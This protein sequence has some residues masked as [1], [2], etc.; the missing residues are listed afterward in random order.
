MNFTLFPPNHFKVWSNSEFQR[1]LL[2]FE[3]AYEKD[4]FSKYIEY[5]RIL[6]SFWPN[7]RG[8]IPMQ[9]WFKY[10]RTWAWMGLNLCGCHT[11]IEL[12][13]LELKTE[14]SI[15]ILF[16]PMHVKSV[17]FKNTVARSSVVSK[18]WSFSIIHQLTLFWLHLVLYWKWSQFWKNWGSRNCVLKMDIF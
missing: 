9:G 7:C 6:N 5:L 13:I 16:T 18:L 10:Y 4:V 12:A 17:H 14:F 3:R 11:L 1:G 15:F 2:Y 8:L